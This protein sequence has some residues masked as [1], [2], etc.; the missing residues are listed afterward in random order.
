M[1]A[2]GAEGRNA[3]PLDEAA[4]RYRPHVVEASVSLAGA[5]DLRAELPRVI[6][7]E[8]GRRGSRP[9]PPGNVLKSLPPASFPNS[10]PNRCL[11]ECP[12]G[13]HA[14]ERSCLGKSNRCRRR[15]RCPGR[16]LEQPPRQASRHDL[17]PQGLLDGTCGSPTRSVRAS[18]R[19]ESRISG[20]SLDDMRQQCRRYRLAYRTISRGAQATDPKLADAVDGKLAD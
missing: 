2:A 3:A 13:L 5:R 19:G 14:I 6:W 16:H 4:E 11:A 9:V 10:S 15:D 18:R 1:V 7:P 12:V 17:T 8:P 20:T